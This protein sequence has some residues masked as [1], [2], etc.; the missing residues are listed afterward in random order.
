MPKKPQG[1]PVLGAWPSLPLTGWASTQ[2]SKW[3]LLLSTVAPPLLVILLVQRSGYLFLHEPQLIAQAA[4][5]SHELLDLGLRGSERG[6]HLYVFLHCDGAVGEVRVQALWKRGGL[7]GKG[8]QSE[9]ERDHV[10]WASYLSEVTMIP[11]SDLLCWRGGLDLCPHQTP[12][13]RSQ[14]DH[15]PGCRY[16]ACHPRSSG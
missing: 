16:S 2:E 15:C 13:C 14:A 1:L 5:S 11:W 9:N 6:F 4:V 10:F 12:R 7:K 3:V 8:I